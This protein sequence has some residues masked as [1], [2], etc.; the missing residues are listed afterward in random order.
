MIVFVPALYTYY[1]KYGKLKQFDSVV[2]PIYEELLRRGIDVKWGIW[3]DE[4]DVYVCSNPYKWKGKASKLVYSPDGLAL[5]EAVYQRCGGILFPGPYWKQYFLSTYSQI[6]PDDPCYP[7]IGWPPLD[8]WFS[9]ERKEKEER[10][11]ETLKL[12]YEKTILFAGLYDG[13]GGF[14]SE[15]VKRTIYKLLDTWTKYDP[16]NVIY[17]GHV[18][19]TTDFAKNRIGR[20]WMPLAARLENLPYGNFVDPFKVGNVFDYSLVS[21]VVVSGESGTALTSF[22]AVGIP[23]IQL[24]MRWYTDVRSLLGEGYLGTKGHVIGYS[25]TTK[26]FRP[27]SQIYLPG[28]VSEAENFPDVVH[29][30]LNHPNEYEEEK[31]A[32]LEKVLY[33]VDG[34]TSQRA[35]DAILTMKE[36]LR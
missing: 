34:K 19:T 18:I 7:L 24:G 27:T 10:L 12:P 17:K 13:M 25:H 21:D 31:K 4:A 22:M 35:A 33:K 5:Q 8:L 3:E 14:A 16:V 23:T 9:S 15:Y 20:G 36:I 1:E 2:M 30:A 32:Y 29:H 6:D 11:R 26:K 28:L